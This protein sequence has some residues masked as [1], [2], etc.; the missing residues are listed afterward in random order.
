M[1]HKDKKLREMKRILSDEAIS[2]PSRSVPSS[3]NLRSEST[4]SLDIPSLRTPSNV[5][6]RKKVSVQ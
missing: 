2:T 1:R 6:T 4:E 5:T 3:Y